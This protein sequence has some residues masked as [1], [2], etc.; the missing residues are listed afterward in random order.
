MRSNPAPAV[1]V[2]MCQV[3]SVVIWL[4]LFFWRPSTAGIPI[5]AADALRFQIANLLIAFVIGSMIWVDDERR[6][7]LRR[8]L[9]VCTSA[10]VLVPSLIYGILRLTVGENVGPAITLS[11]FF[12]SVVAN[13][14][15]L[16]ILDR[17]RRE[18]Q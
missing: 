1:L 5:G 10:L 7:Q 9:T 2:L 11:F 17:I 4:P 16:R 18:V 13:Y 12:V 8:S 6:R 3:L 14:M 15:N